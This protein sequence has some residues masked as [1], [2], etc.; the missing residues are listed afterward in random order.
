M[1]VDHYTSLICI[2]KSKFQKKKQF[3]ALN[4]AISSKSCNVC[5]RKLCSQGQ[6]NEEQG[7]VGYILV[8][9][10]HLKR[11]VGPTSAPLLPFDQL[12]A[13]GSVVN[14]HTKITRPFLF[15]CL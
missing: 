3:K 15:L 5:L 11:F 1:I 8:S 4:S 12:Q 2:L 10:Y 7:K 14:Q 13:A 9:S 6:G